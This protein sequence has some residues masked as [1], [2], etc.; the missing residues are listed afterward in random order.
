MR[1]GTR[2]CLPTN[3][4]LGGGAICT[5]RGVDG[6]QESRKTIESNKRLHSTLYGACMHACIH[7]FI[8][9]NS[10]IPSAP[11]PASQPTYSANLSMEWFLWGFFLLHP[12]SP[13]VSFLLFFSFP[14]AVFFF[15]FQKETYEN[16]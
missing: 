13:C 1:T 12:K 3:G 11:H 4:K 5:E 8:H 16:C 7:S 14:M 9:C 15:L 2:S 6:F 10:L